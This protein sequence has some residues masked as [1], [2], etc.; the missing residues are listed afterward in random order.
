MFNCIFQ[1]S[2]KEVFLFISF[3]LF[4]IPNVEAQ[5]RIIVIDDLEVLPQI[6]IVTF[7]SKSKLI[8]KAYGGE[9]IY[10]INKA[11][12]AAPWMRSLRVKSVDLIYNYKRMQ[13]IKLDYYL[14]NGIFADS[15]ALMAGLNMRLANLGPLEALFSP[16][17]GLTYVGETYYTN[18]NP[19]TSS[20]INIGLRASLKLAL[21]LTANTQLSG[22]I[23]I[24]HY[25]NGAYRVA[26]N[27]MN[28]SSLGLGISRRIGSKKN[29][30]PDTAMFETYKK[31]NLEIGIDMG[32]RGIFRSKKG[33]FRNGLYVG[34]SYRIGEV[35]ALSSGF[36]AVYYHTVFD[37]NNYFYTHQSFGSSYDRIRLGMGIGADLWMGNLAAMFKSGY[38]LHYNSFTDTKTYWTAGLRYNFTK[39][40]AAQGKIYLHG[41]EADYLGFGAIFNIGL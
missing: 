6:A 18:R 30:V 14:F 35:L 29:T 26:N 19:I 31:H 11:H 24:F 40:F 33:V 4:V 32:R 3:L 36:D 12:G 9:I 5:Q 37:P 8:G 1:W 2:K 27:G 34:Y 38:Y 22:G 39:T 20:H 16:A 10:H 21:P 15:H 23:D 13:D 41:T 17:V 7:T 28:L 25:S